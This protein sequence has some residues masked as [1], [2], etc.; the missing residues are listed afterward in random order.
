[1]RKIILAFLMLI[2]Y[3]SLANSADFA[4]LRYREHATDCKSLVDGGYFD[5]C[6]QLSDN[7]WY[8]CYPTTGGVNGTCLTSG[9][10]QLISANAGVWSVLSGNIYNTDFNSKV[11]IGT[12]SPTTELEV[13]GTMNSTQQIT[14]NGDPVCRLSGTGC[15]SPIFFDPNNYGTVNAW[16]TGSAFDWTFASGTTDP[17]FSF[18]DSLISLH[19]SAFRIYGTTSRI[20]FGNS[21]F[22]SGNVSRKMC[23]SSLSGTHNEDLCW[24]ND[25]VNNTWT[26]S[27]NTGVTSIA[28]DLIG[29]KTDATNNN[30]GA[31]S[32][33]TLGTGA[34]IATITG[35]VSIGTANFNKVAPT[36]GLVSQGNIYINTAGGSTVYKKPDG[37]CC[38]VSPDN[39]NN[40][41]CTTVTCP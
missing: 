30:F 38:A 22:I 16:G 20:K 14:V 41:A 39:S 12:S 32:I 37:T 8:A 26:V 5:V 2:I 4:F 1:M 27:S 21:M 36:N 19:D 11:G 28:F 25:S 15:P 13:N 9:E 40:L 29:I 34:N 18:A 3:P 33:G 24:D 31:V 6:R 10:W 7:T 35:G 17:K 23:W